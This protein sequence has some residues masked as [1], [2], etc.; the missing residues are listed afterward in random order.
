MRSVLLRLAGFTGAPILSALAP[1]ILLPVISRIAGAEGWGNFATGQSIGVLGMVVVMFGW[2]V[3]GPVRIAQTDDPALLAAIL[4]ESLATRSVTAVVGLL[5]AGVATALISGPDFR[6]ES[7]LMALAMT[8][9]GLSP[10]WYC[11]GSGRPID[12]MIYDAG[13]KLASALISLPALLLGA[14]VG[15]YPVLLAVF[16]VVGALVHARIALR[17]YP[18]DRLGIRATARV[19]RRL[20]P[21]AAIDAAG[22]AYGST[23]VPIATAGLPPAQASSFASADRLYRVGILVV[24]ALGNAF[25]AWVLEPQAVSRVRRHLAAIA[26][27]A[28]LGLFGALMLVLLGPWASA[29]VFGADVAADP[30]ACTLFGFAFFCISTGTP[31]I[32]NVLIP[33]GRYRYVLTTTITASVVGLTTMGIGAAS[34]SEGL[35]A[36]GVAAAEATSLLML[37]L[38]AVPLLVADAARR[39]TSAP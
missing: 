37:A 1:F 3:V 36:L 17:P 20:L 39:T 31:L 30:L 2:S 24:I 22:N 34:D 23:P 6:V 21:T 26:S 7:V 38:V 19:L 29:F 33:H 13:P 27:H 10:A 8:L 15:L 9:G 35:I 11:I 25:Q 32:R 18:A 4:R 16:T 5:L 28:A 12:L 14:P